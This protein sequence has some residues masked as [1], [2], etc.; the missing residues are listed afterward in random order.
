MRQYNLVFW[1][2]EDDELDDGT[3]IYLGFCKDWTEA[4]EIAKEALPGNAVRL[5]LEVFDS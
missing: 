1:T 3:M 4:L 5:S 2:T